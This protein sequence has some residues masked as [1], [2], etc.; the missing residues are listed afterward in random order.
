MGLFNPSPMGGLPGYR[1]NTGLKTIFAIISVI[2]GI[3]FLNYP[4][5]FF[6][7]PESILK[8]ESWI[9]FAGGILIL[10]G[11]VNYFRASKRYI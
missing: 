11:M 8:F 1:R 6:K 7:V 9:I 5:S 2:F 4:F 3:F 10:V